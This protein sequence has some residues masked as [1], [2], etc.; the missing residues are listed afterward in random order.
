MHRSRAH[1]S[2]GRRRTRARRPRKLTMEQSA[3]LY[4]FLMPVMGNPE[5]HAEVLAKGKV[6]FRNRLSKALRDQRLACRDAI[7]R[8]E[9]ADGAREL[10]AVCEHY[11]SDAAL[12][13]AWHLFSGPGW[14]NTL[15]CISQEIGM[16]LPPNTTPGMVIRYYHGRPTEEKPDPEGPDMELTVALPEHEMEQAVHGTARHR[17]GKFRELMASM[18][19]DVIKRGLVAGTHRLKDNL[20][21]IVDPGAAKEQQE[22]AAADGA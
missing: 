21:R 8:N 11:G 2:K 10:L 13:E 16:K 6:P 9:G 22:R 19:I 5:T 20:G 15:S 12:E 1:K 3:A 14:Q 4:E 18:K 17:K 7:R